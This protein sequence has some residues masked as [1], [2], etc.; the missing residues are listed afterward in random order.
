[1]KKIVILGSTG[2]IGVNTLNVAR[3]LGQN[4]QV[5]ALAARRDIDT[6]EKQAKEFH[7]KLIAV[8]EEEAAKNLRQRLPSIPIVSGME[9][10]KEVA[11]YGDSDLVVS[12]MTGTV[13]LIPT[14]AAIEAGKK[15]A[16]ANKEVLV[17]AG[18]LVMDLVKKK[19]TFLI[20]ID[21]EHSALFQCMLGE[22]LATVKRIILTASGGPFK[23]FTNDQLLQI[24]VEQA[25]CHPN[26][27]M[28]AKITIDCSTLIN[29]G[30]EM[31]EAF[32]LFS[33]APEQ[34]EVIIHPQS[35]I[36]SMVEYQDRSMLAQL[37]EPSMVV[38]IQYALTFPE[39]KPGLIKPFDFMRYSKLEFDLPDTKKFRC[40]ELASHSLKEGKSFPCY[41]NAANEVLVERF[42]KKEIS[43]LDI[44]IKL[45]QL[46]MQH[47]K[48]EVSTLDE[49][50]HVD[51]NARREAAL[52]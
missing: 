21:S 3:H 37:S 36:H 43:W 7:P 1:M 23:N 44:S 19:K 22:D 5:V 49:V 28:G 2:S 8:Y 25:L 27:N 20:P 32:W 35:I 41:L 31:I 26:W 13:G 30:L 33:L 6:L 45:E 42:L 47:K 29:K 46:V 40:L 17:S 16:L 4:Y 11:S 14:L 48:E 18:S 39:R 24:S 12:A 38:A 10:L 50:M 15:I 9:G 51:Q 52:V 34:I